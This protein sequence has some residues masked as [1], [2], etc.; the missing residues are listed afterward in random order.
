MK[1]NFN[2]IKEITTGAVLVSKEDGMISL[3]R[4]TQEQEELYKVTNQD[5]YNKTF[6]H[7]NQQQNNYAKMAKLSY[8]L[9]KCS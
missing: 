2:Q 3:K 4:F 1:L 6:F 8:F 9:H 5:F 7:L